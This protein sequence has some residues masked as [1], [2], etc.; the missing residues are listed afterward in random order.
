MSR[1][2][3]D[4]RIIEKF[5]DDVVSDNSY[6]EL[7][8]CCPYCEEVKGTP[9]LKGNL[10]VNNNNLK[11]FCQ[12]CGSRGYVGDSV[13]GYTF[14]IDPTSVEMAELLD[15]ILKPD[16]S[17]DYC[18]EI[19]NLRPIEGT[20][21]YTYLINRGF[22]DGLIRYYDIRVGSV[23]SKY[24]NR[25]VIPNDV[26]Y[27]EDGR[28]FT[29]MFV[30][31]YF[32][33]IPK[34]PITHKDLIPKYLNPFGDNRRKVVFN[35]HRIQPHQPIIISEGCITSISAGLNSVATYGKYV[36]DVQLYQILSKEPSCVYV[37]LD[38]DAYDTAIN[39]C[40]RI[41]RLCSIPV[42]IVNL[43]DGEDA[44]S[45]GHRKYMEYLNKSKPFNDVEL[46][47]YEIL[48]ISQTN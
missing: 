5:G 19:P 3:I 35:L 23:V 38:P 43:P 2:L 8:Y 48:G 36:T 44:N 32:R 47:I 14:E 34:D 26:V 16:D 9:D 42:Y 28:C 31:R 12:R 27:T 20:D 1:K 46:K 33:E 10:Y 22:T 30:A 21:A 29:D 15:D 40:K 7:V 17:I 11:Y 4:P 39:L 18:Y 6:P 41:Q 37:G 24:K 45:L 25:I 13:K